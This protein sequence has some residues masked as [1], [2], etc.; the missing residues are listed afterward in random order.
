MSIAF[1]CTCG[2]TIKTEDA[3]AGRT[4]RCPH[5]ANLLTVPTRTLGYEVVEDSQ[6]PAKREEVRDKG[7]DVLENERDLPA[8]ERI[9]KRRIT[10][11]PRAGPK[12][13]SIESELYDP[14]TMFLGIDLWQWV[15]IGVFGA[16]WL[17][18]LVCCCSGAATRNQPIFYVGLVLNIAFL[19]VTIVTVLL[20]LLR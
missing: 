8:V 14:G 13:R 7:F 2:K 15:R 3:N 10:D 16:C 6:E 5:C 17:M 1:P 19:L 18:C 11:D 4:V 20:S 9:K 12:R